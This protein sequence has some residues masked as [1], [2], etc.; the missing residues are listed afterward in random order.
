MPANDARTVGMVEVHQIE[1]LRGAEAA[2]IG[3]MVTTM[4]A[5]VAGPLAGPEPCGGAFR[6]A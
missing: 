2:A 4:A 6:L 1:G 3:A 5:S